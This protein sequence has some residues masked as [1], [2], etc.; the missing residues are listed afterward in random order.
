MAHLKSQLILQSGHQDTDETAV[1]TSRPLAAGNFLCLANG[2]SKEY[3][4]NSLYWW[5]RRCVHGGAATT[6]PHHHHHNLTT[7]ASTPFH[8]TASPYHSTTTISL[9]HINP[10]YHITTSPHYTSQHQTTPSRHPH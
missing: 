10:R 3:K 7:S 8:S 4:I 5:K 9:H 6:W 1:S 2:T